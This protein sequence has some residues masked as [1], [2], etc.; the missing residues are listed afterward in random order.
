MDRRVQEIVELHHV[1]AWQ[2]GHNI[3]GTFLQGSQNYGLSHA[4]SDV[5]TKALVLPSFSDICRN[6]QPVSRT[7]VRENNEHI[8]LKDIR[9]MFQNWLKQN[10]NMVEILF[11]PYFVVNPQYRHIWTGLQSMRERIV[12]YDT[13][14][15][16][17][18]CA[19][20][21]MEK[22]KALKHPYPSIVDKIEKYGYDPK[23][24]H[25]ILRM[26]E[27]IERFF[28]NGEKFEACLFSE[29]PDFLLEVKTVPMSLSIAE[30]MAKKA[31]S[32]IDTMKEQYKGSVSEFDV[33][34]YLAG[35]TE[36]IMRINF[37]VEEEHDRHI[38]ATDL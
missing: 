35:V 17:N 37:K 26:M 32:N 14:R 23:Q 38:E 18:C 22:Y 34:E 24:L 12:R 31:M 8:D 7:H 9:L 6:R 27:F 1:E 36:Q 16:I 28:L 15:G 19:G 3:F 29:D 20:M 13:G 11:T 10:I 25:H 4:G 33:P 21:A 2:L 30:E 5:D